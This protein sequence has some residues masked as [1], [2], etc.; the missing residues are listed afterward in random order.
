MHLFICSSI[1][2]F[3]EI[4]VYLSDIGDYYILYILDWSSA[5]GI[6]YSPRNCLYTFKLRFV[7]SSSRIIIDIV[8]YFGEMMFWQS[9]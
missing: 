9:R 6:N 8:P 4:I 3:T 1:Q 5:P 7:N 2:K